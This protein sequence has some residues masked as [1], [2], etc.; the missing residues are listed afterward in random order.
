MTC[1]LERFDRVGK[2]HVR[3]RQAQMLRL[4]AFAAWERNPALLP[5]LHL[6]RQAER[7]ARE[8]LKLVIKREGA[9]ND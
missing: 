7:Q 5:L 6:A 3:L 1:V 2:A 4:D 8:N 9:T